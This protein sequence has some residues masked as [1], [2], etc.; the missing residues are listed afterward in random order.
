MAEGGRQDMTSKIGPEEPRMEWRLLLAFLLTGVVMFLAPYVYHKMYGPPPAAPVKA[1]APASKPA[2][3]PRPAPPAAPEAKPAA[4]IS[5]AQP[6]EQTVETDVYRIRLSNRGAVVLTWELKKYKDAAGKTLQ[7]V[8]AAAAGK[9]GYPF[10]LSFKDRR[11]ALDV[12]QA[13]FAA[14]PAP[15]GL[16]VDYEFSDGRLWVRK[17]FRFEKAR[18]LW[19]FF[20]EARD[21]SGPLP[22]LIQWRGGF[23]DPA[24]D[25]PA[26]RQRTLHF[27][28]AGGKLITEEAKAAKNGPVSAA[29]PFL[30][31]GIQDGYFAAVFLPPAGR[32]VEVQTLSDE[33]PSPREAKETPHVG[34]GVGGEGRNEFAVFVGPK[35]LDVLRQVDRRLEQVVDFGTWFGFI[36]KPLFL[37][38]K[39]VHHNMVGNY[40]WAIVL[41]TVFI[42]FAL[43]PLKFSSLKSMKKMQALQPQ[44]AAIN[45]KYKGISLRDPRKQQQNQ[46]L[47]ELYK[48]HGVNPMGGCVPML[49]QI[50]FFIGF[51]NVLTVAI[52]LRGASWLWVTDLSQP[53]QLPIRILPV[54]MI[55][56]QFAMQKMTP[57]TTADPMQQ[58]MMLLMPL[59]FGFMFYHFSSGLVLY[60]LT[61][62]LVG[63]AQQVLINKTL[64]PPAALP[65]PAV[66]KTAPGGAESRRRKK[67]GR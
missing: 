45:E 41:V 23:G 62:N 61:S 18:Y 33:A 1:P 15:D 57:T 10:A 48:K 30:F 37:I 9:A 28:P 11:P 4:A 56:S 58:R 21:A 38:L 5:A 60:W 16:G 32:S 55:V 43:L 22:H 67:A 39:W 35:D 7:L 12:N 59:V 52:E 19:R 51:Y 13:L 36:A 25:N 31:A 27:D 8:N 17:S 3:A 34:V 20:S 40:G 47:M 26:A 63:I 14:R 46:E 66:A 29:G 49:L 42:N 2:E 6:E 65:G 54:A 24:V 50:P 53:E 44:V 64:P